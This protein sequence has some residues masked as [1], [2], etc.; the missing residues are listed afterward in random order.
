MHPQKFETMFSVGS[1][2]RSYLKEKQRYGS[3]FWVENTHGK[4]VEDKMIP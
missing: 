3:E 2:Q 4:V 1:V